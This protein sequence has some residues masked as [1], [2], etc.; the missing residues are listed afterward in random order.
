MAGHYI[1]AL[2]A[3]QPEGPYLLGGWSLGGMIAFEMAQQLRAQGQNVA[4]LAL[5]DARVMA[6]DEKHARTDDRAL[7]ASLA[8]HLGLSLDQLTFSQDHFLQLEPGQQMTYILEQARAANLVPSDV[9]IAQLHRHLQVLKTNVRAGC[10]YV[11]RPYAGRVVLFRA[12]ERPGV[13]LSDPSMG[14]GKLVAN[15]VEIQ[16]APGDHYTMLRAPH[17]HVLAE[18]LRTYLQEVQA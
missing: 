7:L 4:L 11:P 8:Q 16:M 2:R 9:G 10:S 5:L 15:G 1:E 17:V 13:A 18:G 12:S 3:V 6:P 14:W